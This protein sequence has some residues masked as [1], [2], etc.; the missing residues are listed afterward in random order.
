VYSSKL[1]TEG[2]LFE[3]DQRKII[4]WLFHNNV[5]DVTQLP[6]LEDD[7]AIKKWFA[8]NVRSEKISMFGEID[9]QEIIT[10]HVFSL[11]HTMSH[12]FIKTAGEI[13]GLAGNSLA[14]IIII[15]TASIFIYAQTSQGI[16]L[17]ALSGM[18][19][20]SY[21][22]FLQKTFEDN[23]HCIFDPICSERDQTSCSACVQIP[24]ISC[25]HFNAGLGRKHLYT[26]EETANPITGFWEM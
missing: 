13:S 22:N 16:P 5:I 1:E 9:P 23:R 18:A 12:A 2:L 3:I 14:E 19:E 11:L 15:E 4:E 7:V 6:D 20:N 21:K 26:I 17:G 10:R 24:E 25:N 8:E